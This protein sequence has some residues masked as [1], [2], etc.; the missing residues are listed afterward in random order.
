MGKILHIM[1][2]KL[3]KEEVVKLRKLLPPGSYEVIATKTKQ[4]KDSVVAVISRQLYY[5]ESVI[6]A[7][8]NHLAKKA[9]E[10]MTLVAKSKNRATIDEKSSD[11]ECQGNPC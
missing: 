9:N 1:Y 6:K 3:S 2:K 4:S 7:A 8:L 10:M 11:K 5:N